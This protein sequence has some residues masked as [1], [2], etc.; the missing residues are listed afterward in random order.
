LARFKAK[1]HEI[2]NNKYDYSQII[3]DH[4][5]GKDSKVPVHCLECG[6]NWQPTIHSHVYNKHGCPQCS[7]K[8][9]WTLDRFLK[10]ANEIH[11]DKYDYGQVNENHIEGGG[12]KIPI[13]CH[14]CGYDWNPSIQDHINGRT[15]CPDCAGQVP[16]TLERFLDKAPL[17]HSDKYDYIQI[18]EGHIK[19]AHS[20]IPIHCKICGYD[21]NSTIHKHINS[22][23]GCLEC[24]G[25]VP[26]TLS[27]FKEKAEK[28]HGDKY[29]YSQINENHI[30]GKDSKVPVY[31]KQC[32]HDWQPT[33]HGHIYNQYGC[34]RCA[35]HGM[36]MTLTYFLSR[37][38][39]IHGDKFDYSQITEDDIG[40]ADY[41]S[42][43]QILCKTC[44]YNWRT[45]IASH[46][47]DETGCPNCSGKARWTL[48]RF[49]TKSYEIH[50]NEYDYSE[51]TENHINGKDSKVPVGCR[52]CGCNWTPSIDAHLNSKTGCPN[53]NKSKGEQMTLEILH[54]IGAV[55]IEPQYQHPD[56]R[57][58]KFD[59]RFSY[60]GNNVKYEYDG[61]Q[62]FTHIKHFHSKQS[63]EHKQ[64]ID[65]IK[66]IIAC[67]D[68]NE[69][70][71]RVDYTFN[72]K[73]LIKDFL[74]KALNFSEQFALSTPEMYM[75]LY[76]PITLGQLQQYIPNWYHNW[77]QRANN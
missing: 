69:K 56:A 4:I 38:S 32:E 57:N 44:Y 53:C 1:A 11:G 29:D 55:E 8:A 51:V 46:L 48:E 60:N 52:R 28:V 66:S 62:H 13:H 63:L 64:Q 22:K 19:N 27:R 9:Q 72:T 59:F 67:N 54:E 75:W 37:S 50:G 30:H 25:K 73:D 2:Y 26:W 24:A 23:T 39:D 61:I 18:T 76:E 16:W 12:S 34:P 58:F 49:S 35:N 74:L 14:R 42:H 65:R 20:I 7:G 47:Y 15:G 41:H 77:T 3:E 70:F 21:W 71:I 40:L 68:G 17:I 36:K 5:H 10:K 43:V 6:H 45:S 31:C 33:I